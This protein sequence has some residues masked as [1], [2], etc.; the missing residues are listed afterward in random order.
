MQSHFGLDGV[1]FVPAASPPH[2]DALVLSSFEDRYAMTGLGIHLDKTFVA[3]SIERD[4]NLSGFTIDTLRSL[5]QKYPNV[6]FDLIV[7]ADQAQVLDT[8]NRPDAILQISKVLVGARPGY[9]IHIPESLDRSR[10][11]VVPIDLVDLSS[12]EIRRK[13]EMGIS[14]SDLNRLVPPSVAEY[15]A[16]RKLYLS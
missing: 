4:L 12:S 8:W 9:P 5:G 6:A 2:R 3:E 7:G 10:I 11:A 14:Q 13:I 15:I 1:L 16:H